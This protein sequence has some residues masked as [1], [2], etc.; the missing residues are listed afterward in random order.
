MSKGGTALLVLLGLF[1]RLSLAFYLPGVAPHDYDKDEPVPLLVNSLTPSNVHLKSVI[2]YDYYDPRFQFCQPKEGPIKQWESLGS[3]LFGD[4]IFNSPF[5]LRM[6]KK[7]ECKLLCIS[8]PVK[9]ENVQFIN[10]CVADGYAQNWVV[11][12]L[13]A[14]HLTVDSS[15]KEEDYN[16]G[17]QIGY[18]MDGITALHNHFKIKVEYH[19]R[20]G[21]KFRVVGVVIR[22]ISKDTKVNAKNE[23]LCKA[24]DK[25]FQLGENDKVVYTYDV[26]WEAS[27]TPFSTRWDKYLGIGDASIHWFSLVNSIVIVLFLTGMVAMIMLRALHK[28]ISRYNAVDAQE[29]VQEDYGWKLV[30]GDVFRPP[31]RSILL[32]VLVG[33]GAQ[34]VAMT[35]L[36]LVF[37]VLGFLSP[38]NRGALAT[39]MVIFFMIFSCIAGYVSARIYKM[40]GGEAWKVNML[41]TAT[42]FP[43]TILGSLFALNFFLIG[44]QSSGAV[45]FGTMIALLGMWG[46]IS[47]PLTV[48]GAYF[49]FRKP[50]IEH[51]VR[52]N[53][54]PRQ[55]PDQP[56]YLR[57]IPSIMMG[58]IL[59]FGAIFIELYF[60]MNSIWFHRIYYGIGFWFLVFL[61]LILTCTQVAILMCY[62]HLCNEDYHW[63]WRSFLTSGATGAYV[64]LY[65]VLYYFTKLDISNFTSMVL[66]FGYSAIISLITTVMTGTIGY[67][68]CLY[69]L[70]KIFASIKVD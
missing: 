17:F 27:K 14:A 61:V 44:S 41:L 12:G 29:D 68:A 1:C 63:S 54:I 35:G 52:T 56:L 4:R 23:P 25:A 11:D 22:A 8:E 53:Q 37:A 46:L 62:F 49:G 33:S 16:I 7:E 55:I 31:V 70:H 40:N 39:V 38:S 10:Q 59:P 43:G 13:P 26:E 5:E 42:V 3:I 9:K 21:N 2:S 34:L 45:P 30:H 19:D 64:F 18:K 67:L 57:S 65:S 48:V 6:Q 47:L 50:R 51:P 15:K 60:I 36:T 32:S 66:Y 28:D 20:P 58:G 24:D 69:F